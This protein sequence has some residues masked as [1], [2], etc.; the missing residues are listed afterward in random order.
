M[1]CDSKTVGHR[2]KKIPA[3]AH[4]GSSYA[5]SGGQSRFGL[6]LVTDLHQSKAAQ[7]SHPEP[8]IPLFHAVVTVTGKWLCIQAM[9]IES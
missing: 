2:V 6:V 9:A 3:T 5:C 1:A 4:I 8:I 7:D